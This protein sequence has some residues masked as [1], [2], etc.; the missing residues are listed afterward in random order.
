MEEVKEEYKKKLK[1]F[2]I[3]LVAVLLITL[4]VLM[5]VNLMNNKGQ[6]AL[7]QIQSQD[8]QDEPNNDSG[9]LLGSVP[10]DILKG[11]LLESD[12]PKKGNLLLVRLQGDV[13]LR[14]SRDFGEF[15]NKEVA[16]LIDGNLEKFRLVD[17]ELD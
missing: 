11:V 7:D 9:I 1:M 8:Q 5:V 16:V 12:D 17:I 15:L 14:T 4:I 6:Q 13:Y 10:T 3:A 2:G